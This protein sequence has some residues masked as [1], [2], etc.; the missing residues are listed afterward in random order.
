MSIFYLYQFKFDSPTGFFRFF[1]SLD[2]LL[3]EYACREFKSDAKY[4][5]AQ[6]VVTY[7]ILTEMCASWPHFLLYY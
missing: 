3:I 1:F 4:E 7:V 2:F 6:S 5:N